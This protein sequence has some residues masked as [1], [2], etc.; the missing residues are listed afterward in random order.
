GL[1]VARSHAAR[2]VEYPAQDARAAGARP[3]LHGRRDRQRAEGARGQDRDGRD[4][5]VPPGSRHGDQGAA[6]A[7]NAE[8]V[9]SLWTLL[10]LLV[11]LGIVA[12][13]WSGRRKPRFE[14]AARLA[15]DDEP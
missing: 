9:H 4:H 15:L 7:M 6:L 13:A 8:L 3:P 2:R 12:W 14:Q 1:S 5:R 10:L 11:F